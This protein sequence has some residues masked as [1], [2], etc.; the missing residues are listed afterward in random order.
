MTPS[1]FGFLIFLIGAMLLTA[2]CA[3]TPVIKPD[4]WNIPSDHYV[5]ID[6]HVSRNGEVIGGTCDGGMMIDFPMY[7]FNRETGELT[8]MSAR[9]LTVNESLKIVYGDG[10][11][12]GGAVGSGVSTYLTP[13]YMLPFEKGEIIITGVAP[14]GRAFMVN[15]NSTIT[16]PAGETW[17]NVTVSIESTEFSG[18]GNTCTVKTVRTETIYNAGI[19]EK[20]RIRKE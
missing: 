20:S 18:S 3:N 16:L 4:P 19:M 9:D 2:G 5:F 15:G 12:I 13:G 10:V 8:G 11:S 7:S 17:T 6:H 1:R 14:D